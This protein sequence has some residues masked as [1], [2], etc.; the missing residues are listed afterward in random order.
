MLP[1]QFG[2]K[3]G[4]PNFYAYPKSP[5]HETDPLGLLQNSGGLGST[6]IKKFKATVFDLAVLGACQHEALD[7][8][9][10][11]K[12]SQEKRV[13]K[14]IKKENERFQK[15][16]EACFENHTDHEPRMT[17]TNQSSEKR[18]QAIDQARKNADDYYQST[19]FARIL[20]FVFCE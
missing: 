17:C 8:L 16:Y 6:A 20:N 2:L 14:I 10:D 18:Y 1:P 11:L 15:E 13:D 3:S 9:A 19:K 12:D 4:E 7:G 5:L